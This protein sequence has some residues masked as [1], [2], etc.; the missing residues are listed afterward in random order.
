M[1]FPQ[2]T[3]LALPG[4][5]SVMTDNF[6]PFFPI[7]LWALEV[8]FRL[9]LSG[10]GTVLCRYLQVTPGQ[11]IPDTWRYITAHVLRSRDLGRIPPTL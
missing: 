7:S 1:P 4:P 2:G 11:L 3:V 8:G 6:A 10:L 9:P 5:R